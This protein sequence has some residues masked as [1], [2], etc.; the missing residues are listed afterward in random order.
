M[1]ATHQDLRDRLR[2]AGQ[3][4]VLRFHDEL[5]AR[6]RAELLEDLAALDWKLVHK[7]SGFAQKAETAEV[8]RIDPPE[9]VWSGDAPH[10]A[11]ARGRGIV[12]SGKVAYILVAGGQA[13]RLGFDQ[14][15]GCFPIGPVSRRPLFQIHADRLRAIARKT[16]RTPLWFVMTSPANHE[17]TIAFFNENLNFG[18]PAERI[19]FYPQ[20][21]VPAFDR[22]GKLVLETKSRLF[23]NPNGHGGALW[24][25]AQSGFLDRCRGE[26]IEHLFYWQ[27]DN[28][29]VR[30]GDPLFLGLH[31]ARAGAGMSSKIVTKRGP[32]EK[33]GVIARRGGREHCIEYSDL[34][35]E[36]RD[37]R[38]ERG[39][40]LYRAGN[41][42]IH[43]FRVEFVA[44]L[45]RG[46]L[47]LPWH[48]AE[49]KM[50]IVDAAGN[51]AEISG[52][53][54]ETFIFDALP[55]S[56]RTVTLEV[57]REDEFAPVKNAQ[58]EDSPATAR[59]AICEYY[60][61]WF[62][63]AGIAAPGL[64]SRPVEIHPMFAFDFV[65][66]KQKLARIPATGEGPLYLSE[67]LA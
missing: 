37:A 12:E 25:L 27:V 47:Q 1:N 43:A 64:E 36:L 6:G 26:G 34:P 22:S 30:L 45:T 49:K 15:K 57:K 51:R 40:L 59:E 17:T 8:G 24:A 32:G 55:L 9:V 35:A 14:P 65:E 38:D 46:E 16:G 19:V 60:R 31:D 18:L 44:S 7:L 42:A 56:E 28:P 5:D 23:R 33:V 4:H 10:A 53:K 48:R 67:E 29:L 58:G 2:A 13:T 50:N 11:A 63:K 21:T 52:V 54:F 3:E 61:R 20:A 39:N 66:F 41:I 62:R